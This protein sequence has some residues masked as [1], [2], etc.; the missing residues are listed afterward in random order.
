MLP[1]DH[2]RLERGRLQDAVN[3]AQADG[4][5]QQV[6]QELH[7]AAIRA[8]AD[9]R[10]PDDHLVQPCLG[11]RHLEQHLMVGRRRQENVIQRR[12]SLVRLLVD[13]LAAHPVPGRQI[14]DCR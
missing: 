4:H 10:Q 14:A 7:D 6:A 2:A 1:V 5:T 12:D 11:D 9:Q 13:E 8:V 3:A